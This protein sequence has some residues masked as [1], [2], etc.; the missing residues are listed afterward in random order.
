MPTD[1]ERTEHEAQSAMHGAAGATRC[2]GPTASDQ[3]AAATWVVVDDALVVGIRDLPAPGRDF[4]SHAF[5]RQ[6]CN[7]S[8][9]AGDERQVGPAAN[10]RLDLQFASPCLGLC[11]IA[12]LGRGALPSAVHLVPTLPHAAVRAPVDDQLVIEQ[13]VCSWGPFRHAHTV[14]SRP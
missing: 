12:L 11:K 10:F 7:V 2:R 13:D 14:A 8:E 1:A 4:L 6:L 3:G 5:N 9:L